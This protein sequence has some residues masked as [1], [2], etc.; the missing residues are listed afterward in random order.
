MRTTAGTGFVDGN[1]RFYNPS[2]A[3]PPN[4]PFQLLATR[5]MAGRL[6]LPQLERLLTPPSDI[7]G[8]YQE[9]DKG[10]KERE[11]AAIR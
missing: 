1:W 10:I 5:L 8:Y 7:L 9:H 2:S 6:E 11:D 4:T 3:A